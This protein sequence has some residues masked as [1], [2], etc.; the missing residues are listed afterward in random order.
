MEQFLAEKKIEQSCVKKTVSILKIHV[1]GPLFE[2]LR[3]TFFKGCYVPYFIGED[4]VVFKK[5]FG[6]VQII[7]SYSSQNGM[8]LYLI[9]LF[10]FFKKA[11]QSF[12]W[13]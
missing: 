7:F 3:K 2:I 12:K 10:F 13:A 11:P 8:V 4:Q 6:S 9:F 5:I 1:N